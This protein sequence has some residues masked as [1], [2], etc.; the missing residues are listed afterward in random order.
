MPYL[1]IIVVVLVV[2]IL[3]V[4]LKKRHDEF[5]RRIR[6][7]CEGNEIE[8][9]D[10]AVFLAA[11]ESKGSSQIQGLGCLILTDSHLCF[12]MQ[13][14]DR[15]I[16]IPLGSITGVGE[17]FRMGGKSTGK[18][19]LRIDYTIDEV[20]DALALSVDK[21]EEWKARLRDAIDGLA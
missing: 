19:W 9:V 20:D 1:S 17:T 18:L 13:M 4:F 14:F 5:E 6:G 3:V 12:E 11:Q 2:G 8:A 16:E 10:R 21:L 7:R 15:A